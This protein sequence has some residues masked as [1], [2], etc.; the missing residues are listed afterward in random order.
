MNLT[1]KEDC[2]ICEIFFYLQVFEK[3]NFGSGHSLITFQ[4]KGQLDVNMCFHVKKLIMS[5]SEVNEYY[6]Y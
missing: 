6:H 3:I 4:L 1:Q 2:R 5:Q